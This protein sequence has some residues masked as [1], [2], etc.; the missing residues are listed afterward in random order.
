LGFPCCLSGTRRNPGCS[1]GLNLSRLA[2]HFAL[3]ALPELR[4]EHS[5]PSL[6]M[7]GPDGLPASLLPP[8]AP[9]PSAFAPFLSLNKQEILKP[10]PCA[11][12]SVR[13]RRRRQSPG[14]APRGICDPAHP[15]PA[16]AHTLTHAHSSHTRT[17]THS[18]PPAPRDRRL[19]LPRRRNAAAAG[20]R[21]SSRCLN[22]PR[23]QEPDGPVGRTGGRSAT[24]GECGATSQLGKAP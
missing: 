9:S 15:R 6:S 20:E 19:A 2:L 24:G 12:S 16:R 18:Y 4:S 3:F 5:C 22:A 7:R 11:G 23:C 8:S 1:D 10:G 14:W 21:V 17:N 13:G